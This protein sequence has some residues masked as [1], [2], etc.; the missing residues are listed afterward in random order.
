MSKQN[1][2]SVF[3]SGMIVGSAIGT[4]VGLLIAPRT[5]KETRKVLKKSVEALPDLAEDL[6]SSL[7]LQADRLSDSALRNW[8]ETLIRLK[9]AIAA[10][11]EASQSDIKPTQNTTELSQESNSSLTKSKQSQSWQGGVP[12]TENNP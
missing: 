9:D 4:I 3:V 11:L 5:G 8:D 1:R 2:A 6:S 10:G 7:L 12:S